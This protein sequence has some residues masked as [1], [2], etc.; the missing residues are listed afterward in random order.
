MNDGD[1]S[2]IS[3]IDIL[4]R[5]WKSASGKLRVKVTW[6]HGLSD[7]AVESYDVKIY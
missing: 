5:Y 3:V 2:D 1:K 6:L 4:S 7:E